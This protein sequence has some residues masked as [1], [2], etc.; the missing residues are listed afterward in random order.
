MKLNRAGMIV[1]IFLLLLLTMAGASFAQAQDSDGDTVPD[2][3]DN[4][5]QE[6]GTVANHGCPDRPA[7]DRDSDGV[8]DFVDQCPDAAGTG[9]SNG[10]PTGGT[11]PE[12]T[13]YVPI[14]PNWTDPN[15]CMVGVPVNAPSNVNVRALAGMDQEILGTV[16][17]GTQWEPWLRDYDE[18]NQ[19][20]FD[21]APV[22]G[23]WV[24]GDQ[25]I[26]HGDCV[27]LP[28]VI[29]VDA[30]DNSPGIIIAD[31]DPSLIPHLGPNDPITIPGPIIID[32]DDIPVVNPTHVSPPTA[33]PNPGRMPVF[34]LML[35]DQEVPL[36]H[37]PFFVLL[38]GEDPSFPFEAFVLMPEFGDGE[39]QCTPEAWQ[40]GMEDLGFTDGTDPDP[41]GLLL[42]AV[43]KV[44]EAASR[45]RGGVNV[46]VGDLTGDGAQA[47]PFFMLGDGSVRM[48]DGSV[49][50]GDGGCATWVFIPDGGA[51]EDH[52]LG[53]GSFTGLVGFGLLLP[54]V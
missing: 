37:K 18:T 32:M 11:Q 13:P 17:P 3:R 53:G 21:G 12:Q 1:T 45:A 34:H 39:G 24:R 14:A 41:I 30:P 4:C 54:A 36:E 8:A 15:A 5:P 9:F 20:W 23:G 50:P 40:Q 35:G 25:V 43:Q 52:T 22:Q 27:Y 10:C 6:F 38:G 29:H 33:T 42:P 7:D 49:M 19:I 48:G 51:A 16:A 2:T 47:S 26:L 31:F 28:Q 46:A 44:R